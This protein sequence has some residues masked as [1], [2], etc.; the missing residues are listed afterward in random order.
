[1]SYYKSLKLYLGLLFIIEVSSKLI[2]PEYNNGDVQDPNLDKS[3]SDINGQNL[4]YL[5]K[6]YDK[7]MYNIVLNPNESLEVFFKIY[8][9]SETLIEALEN[10]YKLY[11]G[12]DFMIKNKNGKQYNTDIII[13]A[14]DKNDVNCY[15]YVYDT[16]NDNY[17]RNDN[18]TISR[19]DII[20]LGFENL[21]LNI[22]SKNVVGYKNY[23][24]VRFNKEFIEPYQNTTLYNWVKF[25][26][27]DIIHKVTGFYG[28]IGKEED[29]NEFSPNFPIYYEKLLFE[30]GAGLKRNNLHNNMMQSLTFIIYGLILYIT[31]VFEIY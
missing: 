22:L 21:T 27:N 9:D 16:E 17:I 6:G 12:F 2:P 7:T 14:F 11:F 26:P 31:F 18:G 19:N 20:P 10:G 28:L 3:Y 15:D 4:Y 13:C 8:T 24:C 1:M 29:L 5:S 23:Y 30:N 25:F